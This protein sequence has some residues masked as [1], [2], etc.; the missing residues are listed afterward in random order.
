MSGLGD[1][2]SDEDN[3]KNK[4]QCIREAEGIIIRKLMGMVA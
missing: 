3:N 2:E 1:R 4:K